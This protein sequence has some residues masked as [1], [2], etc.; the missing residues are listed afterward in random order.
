MLTD[1]TNWIL[2]SFFIVGS[3]GG[4]VY[5]V[6]LMFW[7]DKRVEVHHRYYE[8][9]YYYGPREHQEVI[10]FKGRPGD[11]AQEDTDKEEETAR[12]A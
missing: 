4:I 10:P 12:G 7:H 2:F 3:L 8:V 6:R 5:F 11:M 1:L 9:P